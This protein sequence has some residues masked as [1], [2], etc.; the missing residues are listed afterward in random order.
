MEVL[1]L[2]ERLRNGSGQLSLVNEHDFFKEGK[3]PNHR[4]NLTG[5]AGPAGDGD[6]VDASRVGIVLVSAPDKG[7]V[8][9]VHVNVGVP[10]GKQAHAA[11]VG[12]D[13]EKDGSVVVIAEFV[14][15]VGEGEEIKKDK[16]ETQVVCKYLCYWRALHFNHKDIHGSQ[17]VGF[18]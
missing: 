17:I 7:P 16:I 12:L 4:R 1:E 2:P 9:A 15:G 3:V 6:P 8:A 10:V 13:L 18:E 11:E 14:C 5:E